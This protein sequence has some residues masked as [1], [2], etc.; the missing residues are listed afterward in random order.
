MRDHSAMHTTPTKSDSSLNPERIADNHRVLIV[1]GLNDSDA[2][3]WQTLWQQRIANS[4][5]IEVEDWH[6]ADLD[7]WRTAI[8]KSLSSLDR[9][10]ILI[11][12]SFGALAAASIA[13]DYPELIAGLFLVAPADPEKFKIADRLPARR[14]SVP[15]HLIASD[16]DPWMNIS[17]AE[18]WALTWGA[19]FLRLKNK[20]HINSKSAVGVW[21][22]GLHQLNALVRRITH[23][24]NN[25]N[26]STVELR[27]RFTVN[28]PWT[29]KVG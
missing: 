4:E 22:E 24:K 27:K 18:H 6:E 26:R 28:S 23:E 1:P 11:A 10:A 29:T 17:E 14:L 13:A 25:V 3:H 2:N 19:N 16:N 7:K 8:K 12:H 20:G 5:R 9:P 15:V 21:Q